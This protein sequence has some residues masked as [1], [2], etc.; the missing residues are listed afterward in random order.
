MKTVTITLQIPDGVNVAV[1][2]GGGGSDRPFVPRDDPPRPEGACPVH[3][4]DWKL[5][6]AGVSRKSGKQYNGFWVCSVQGC[7]QKP[8][9]ESSFTD[10]TGDLPW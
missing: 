5:V 1:N 6:P 7:D 8:G 3:D 4:A 2:N 10:V 9:R